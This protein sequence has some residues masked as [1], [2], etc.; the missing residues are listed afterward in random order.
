MFCVPYRGRN[1]ERVPGAS[2]SLGRWSVDPGEVGRYH[3][4]GGL[5]VE[6]A[7]RDDVGR[8]PPSLPTSLPAARAS[9]RRPLWKSK[10]LEWMKV[11]RGTRS[12]SRGSAVR[13]PWGWGELFRRRSR[14][15]EVSRGRG[16]GA[17]EPVPPGS[18][19]DHGGGDPPRGASPQSLHAAGDRPGVASSIQRA[20]YTRN[21]AQGRP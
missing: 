8:L 18:P 19:L 17:E 2:Q 20:L 4:E 7:R 6:A 21:Y 9:W 11:K 13:R 10:L 3:G 14:G 16:E 5:R 15:G 1:I 12:S